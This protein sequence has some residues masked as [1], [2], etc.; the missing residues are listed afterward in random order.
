MK[1]GRNTIWERKGGRKSILW[2]WERA[3]AEKNKEKEVGYV[4][5]TKT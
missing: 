4:H 2:V 1:S 3:P 5:K